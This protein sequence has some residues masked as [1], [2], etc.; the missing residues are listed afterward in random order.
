MGDLTEWCDPEG[1]RVSKILVNG[2]GHA[3]PAGNDSSGGG[4][5][6]DHNHINLSCL[7][8]RV[9]FCE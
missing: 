2:M 7:D 8:H 4:S 3:W 5:Y 6:I 1:P 9:V